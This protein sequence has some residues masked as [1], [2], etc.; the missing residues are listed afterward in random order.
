MIIRSVVVSGAEVIDASVY[1]SRGANII[2]GGSGT[3]KSYIVE[4]IQFALGASTP[5]KSIIQSTGYTSVKVTFEHYDQRTFSIERELTLGSKAKLVDCDGSTHTLGVRHN[6]KDK[7]TVSSF[8]LDQMELDGKLL[9]TGSKSLNAAS[10]SLRDFEKLFVIDEARIVAK[11]SPLGTGQ[12]GEATKEKSILKLLL[13]GQ[14]DSSVKE[15]KKDVASKG[16]LKQ[17]AEALEDIIH[18]FYSDGKEGQSNELVKFHSFSGVVNEKLRKAEAEL[19]DAFKSSESLFDDKAVNISKLTSLEAKLAEDNVLNGRFTVLE[20]KYNSD[21]ERLLAIEQTTAFLQIAED[22]LC[23]TCGSQFDPAS[24]TDINDFQ[25]GVVYELSRIET[26]LVELSSAKSFVAAA[27]QRG[28]IDIE[29]VKGVISALDSKISV[30][31][32][33]RVQQVSDLKELSTSISHDLAALTQK[34]SAK[35]RLTQELTRLSEML[36]DKQADYS[37]EEFD[38]LQKALGVK[39][40]EILGRWGFPDCIPVTFDIKTRDI[41]IGGSPRKNF[42]KGHRAVA[43]S[44]FVLGL[45]E[46]IKEAGR[47]PGFVVLDS[48]LTAYKEG[49]GEPDGERDEVSLDLVYAFYRDIAD[50]YKDSQVII[51]ENKEPDV[52]IIG[53]VDY[54]HFTRSRNHGRFGFFPLRD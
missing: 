17:K 45:M 32:Q 3:G 51:L 31:I 35:D 19:A 30:G 20:K 43:F 11:F 9:L 5:P 10:F 21:R 15:V 22:V 4:C 52:G 26:N 8:F 24:C 27:I 6:A 40:Q 38:E 53:L 54:Q 50:N 34:A 28:S 18:R 13:T 41:V 42:G 46:V 29:I 44:A 12:N 1:F 2:Q 33:D 7:A 36:L 39:I 16:L 23:P 49:D 25:K 37:V 47:H 14:D 48:P